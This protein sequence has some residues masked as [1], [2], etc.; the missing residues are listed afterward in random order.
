M[1][2]S[3]AGS[4]GPKRTPK[5]LGF[6]KTIQMILAKDGISAFWR[7][8]GPALI[9][10]INPV[11]QYTVFEQLK[12]LLVA[13]RTRKLKAAGV[14]AAAAALTDWDFF[15]LGAISKLGST[16]DLFCIQYLIGFSSC[17]VGDVSLH[18]S[19]L[20]AFNILSSAD[21]HLQCCQESPASWEPQIQVFNGWSYHHTSGRRH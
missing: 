6:L 15:F 3:S 17:N 10:V 9:L 7:G 11:L 12:N 16:G 21:Q 14:A 5:K 4:S 20:L 18:V 1:D 8:I 13:S 2:E 19:A